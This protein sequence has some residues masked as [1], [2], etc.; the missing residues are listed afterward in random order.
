MNRVGA[1]SVP[2]RRTGADR[3]VRLALARELHDVVAQ[4]LATMLLDMEEFKA[5]QAGRSS[6]LREIDE[7]QTA[8]RDVLSSLRRVLF[9]LRDEQLENGRVADGVRGLLTALESKTGIIGTLTVTE[10][11]PAVIANPVA[12]ELY[13][14]VQ[15]ALRNVVLHSGARH[16]EVALD[17]PPDSIMVSVRDDGHGILAGADGFG[18]LGMRER[19]VLLG[20]HLV[21]ESTIGDG[22]LVQILVPTSHVR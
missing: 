9:Q 4:S 2:N 13:R 16:V 18:T 5:E 1:G 6:V 15:E 7:L 19:A 17:A 8:T 10:R 22:C 21:V 3:R 11:W 14:I 12:S 20:G